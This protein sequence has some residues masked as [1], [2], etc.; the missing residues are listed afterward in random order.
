MLVFTYSRL[1]FGHRLARR[2]AWGLA[3]ACLVGLGAS[4]S[5][6][7]C[8][9]PP[10]LPVITVD[11]GQ[12]GYDSADVAHAL[13]LCEQADG[14]VLDFLAETYEDIAIVFM[15]TGFECR[16]EH[17]ICDEPAVQG[18]ENEYPNGIVFRGQGSGTVL[19]SPVWDYQDPEST[20][21]VPM[22]D[23]R[24]RNGIAIQ[25]HD[26]VLDGRKS[27]QIDPPDFPEA[28]SWQHAA[29][30]V[31]SNG[32]QGSAP[33]TANGCLSNVEVRNFMSKGISLEWVESWRLSNVSVEDIGCWDSVTPCPLVDNPEWLPDPQ[34]PPIAGYHSP[35]TALGIY[36]GSRSVD[37]E[38][39]TIRRSTKNA[40]IAKSFS[41][42]D[43]EDVSITR[44]RVED[45]GSIAFNLGN[46]DGVTLDRAHLSRTTSVG[47][48]PE[49]LHANE[50][51]GIVC[52]DE[53][54]DVSLR[55]VTIEQM[56][57]VGVE[58]SCSGAGNEM[59]DVFVTGSC[60]ERNPS[61]CTPGGQC[62]VSRDFT[63]SGGSSGNI[64][65]VGVEV[66]SSAC[67]ASF[68]VS[69]GAAT[70]VLDVED[71]TLLSDCQKADPTRD[72]KV[73]VP[74]F[75]ILGQYYG[76]TCDPFDPGAPITVTPGY[77]GEI[78]TQLPD[79]HRVNAT[80]PDPAGEPAVIGVP[81]FG[82]FGQYFGTTCDL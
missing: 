67:F 68:F 74:D 72:R 30:Q 36:D 81:D 80:R 13:A 50:T 41:S 73:G 63:V 55:N 51:F 10:F 60:R 78:P 82:I 33:R 15:M 22:L 2:L 29:F 35:A 20:Y 16:H 45:T 5:A 75:G 64:D 65:L 21:P 66:H 56:A 1:G 19:R 44:L 46:V 11:D 38:D 39:V 18:V 14:C 53:A 3:A 34:L 7:P 57:G 26:L 47:M 9:I 52:F 25:L 23:F 69:P 42:F 49:L 59:V 71:P 6:D 27:E 12:G 28:A 76:T 17:T 61:T 24:N 58:W 79:C 77:D 62:Y 31:S 43:V 4:A 37:L 48:P 54:D 40:F 8:A 70:T 32:Q